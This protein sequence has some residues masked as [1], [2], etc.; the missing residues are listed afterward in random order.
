MYR[1]RRR[2]ILVLFTLSVELSLASSPEGGAKKCVLASYF[3]GGGI[4]K[5]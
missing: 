2:G 3:G 1:K 5:Q 4:A